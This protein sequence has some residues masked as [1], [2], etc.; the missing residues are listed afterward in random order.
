MNSESNKRLRC[1]YQWQFSAAAGHKFRVTK[2]EREN[3]DRGNQFKCFCAA[4]PMRIRDEVEE[5]NGESVKV[6][7]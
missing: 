7:D 6:I 4:F 1:Y 2:C 5:I 3:D